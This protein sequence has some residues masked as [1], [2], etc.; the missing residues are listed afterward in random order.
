[1]GAGAALAIAAAM[2]HGSNNGGIWRKLS[3]MA[4]AKLERRIGL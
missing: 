4:S 2:Q 1:V 3:G